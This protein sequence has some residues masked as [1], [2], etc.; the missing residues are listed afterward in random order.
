MQD[1]TERRP[2]DWLN[3]ITHQSFLSEAVSMEMAYQQL[4]MRGVDYAA[5]L[6]ENTRIIGLISF[7]YIASVLSAKFGQAVFSKK[8]L[9]DVKVSAK[10][11]GFNS[12]E[13]DQ[14]IPVVIPYSE[15]MILS[16]HMDFFE[17]QDQFVSR[18]IAR[19]FEDIVVVDKERR[20][21]GLLSAREFIRIQTNVVDWQKNELIRRNARV[22]QMLVELTRTQRE[23]LNSAKM[24]ALGE[25]VAG[26]AHEMNTP[27]GILLSSHD[28]IEKAFSLWENSSDPERRQQLRNL[29]RTNFELG[30]ESSD[31]V[32]RIIRSLK[33]F[34]RSDSDTL[35]EFDLR[36]LLDAA[37][38]LLGNKLKSRVAVITD[39]P[40]QACAKGYPS[41]LSQVFLNVL[42]NALQA[43][44]EKGEIHICIKEQLHEWAISIRDTGPG[45]DPRIIER[46][47][48]PGFTTKGVGV[49]TGLGLSISR[50]IVELNHGGKITA[51]NAEERGAVITIHLPRH[52]SPKHSAHPHP[53]VEA[54]LAE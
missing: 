13:E 48:D 33:T 3:H 23:L 8:R 9:M 21:Q 49:G 51:G 47:F 39:Y 26:I 46:I 36:D 38:T 50:K 1:Q 41:Q 12:N 54:H 15:V 40:D 52:G 20:Y 5:V 11:L 43:I 16:S 34:G 29:I 4:L 27:I 25:L 32:A 45:I 18:P 30:R 35:H 22:E 2:I 28:V 42:T 31:R 10:L 37:V 17:A 14:S 24:A 53:M 7:K 6:D 44:G 19:Y